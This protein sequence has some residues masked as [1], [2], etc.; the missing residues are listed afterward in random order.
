MDP[1]SWD[2]G[3]L[4]WEH[5]REN[6]DG[7]LFVDASTRVDQDFTQER[8]DLGKMIVR[9]MIRCVLVILD[10]SDSM[11]EKEAKASNKPGRTA[12]L[13]QTLRAFAREFFDQNSL[14][15]L[16]VI[17]LFHSEGHILV[18][19][20][21]NLQ[22]ILSFC[23]K[24]LETG[25]EP[26]IRN[27]LKTA[28]IVLR[29]IPEYVSKEILILYS[30]VRTCDPT[31]IGDV[32]KDLKE[33]SV[34]CFVVSFAGELHVLTKLALDTS[35][36]HHVPMNLDVTQQILSKFTLPFPVDS[37]SHSFTKAIRPIPIGIPQR[38]SPEDVEDNSFICPQ[39]L[40]KTSQPPTDCPVCG[41]LLISAH[42][43]SRSTQH[44][45]PLIAF[46]QT[47]DVPEICHGCTQHVSSQFAY[48]CPKCQQKYCTNCNKFLHETLNHCPSCPA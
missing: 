25:G 24:P 4:P 42:H 35:G 36:S 18:M 33:R 38:S 45:F 30:S 40:S 39:C 9:H 48:E 43:L 19:P 41:L 1:V 29:F 7:T 27:G 6:D 12:F 16:G 21:G 20:T 10:L 31:P 2:T 22:D 5:I 13:K 47:R 26:S 44:I 37:S 23:D 3:T 8:E 17:G 11:E 32:V 15:R 14:S 46:N 34:R 28:H